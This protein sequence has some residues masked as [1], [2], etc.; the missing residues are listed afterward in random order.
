MTEMRLRSLLLASIFIIAMLTTSSFAIKTVTYTSELPRETVDWEGYHTLP[1]F[2]PALGNLVSVNFT[3]SLNATMDG[4]A[5]NNA[6]SWFYDAYFTADADMYVDMLNGEKLTLQLNLETDHEDLAPSTP[7]Y[8]GGP[9]YFA[10]SDAGDTSGFIYYNDA[11]KDDFVGTGNINL[12]TKSTATSKVENSG[13]SYFLI[14]TYSWT[15]ASITYTYDECRSCI[16][17]YKLDDCTKLGVKDWKVTLNNST[18]TTSTFTDSA[19]KYE[20][21]GLVPGD[22]IIT[23]DTPAGY[24]PAGPV[25]IAA[26]LKC[27]E[28]L[29]DQNFTNQ[30]LLCISG[31]KIN[32]STGAGLP[33][34]NITLTNASGSVTAKTGPDGKYQFC[35]LLPG[36]YSLTEEIVPGYLVVQKVSNPF[37][38]GCANITNKN[39]TNKWVPNLCG[40]CW[41]RKPTYLAMTYTGQTCTANCN[42]Q[43]A[44][45]VIVTGDPAGATPVRIVVRDSSSTGTIWFDRTVALGD[46]FV[47]DPA[48]GGATTLGTNT[49]VQISSSSG[50]VLQTVL[51]HTSCSQP[52]RP[53]DMYGSLRLEGCT[54]T[55]P[56]CPTATD[57]AYN[58][59]ND[60]TLAVAASQGVLAND[61]GAEITILSNTQPGNGT[62]TLNADGSFT[63][64]PKAGYCGTDRFSYKITG[65]GCD[66]GYQ[67]EANVTLNVKCLWCQVSGS[68][69]LT[70]SGKQVSWKITNNGAEPQ[71]IS[72]IYLAWPSVNKKEVKVMLNGVEI[73]SPDLAAPSATINSGWKGTVAARTI[74]AGKTATLTFEFESTACTDQSGYTINV[75]FS[76]GCSA[77]L[78]TVVDCQAAGGS[79]LTISAKK[80]SWTIKNNG[81]TPLDIGGIDLTWPQT[82]GKEMKVTLDGVEIYSPDLPAPSASF[83]SG[84]KGTLDARTI[85]PGQARILTFEFEKTASTSQSGYTINVRLNPACSLS[86]P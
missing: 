9:D 53:G 71:D 1:K 86:F 64:V 72:S 10:A 13:N 82:N 36:S 39:F 6:N 19:G 21:C 56:A 67:D 45:K 49:Y 7:P 31:Y 29:T 85:Q 43:A 73:Y 84:W 17:G 54:G 52:L 12:K 59:L 66:E 25:S 47:I 69:A 28:N 76:S 33:G 11:R 77:N 83:C 30:K 23:E 34:W 58:A 4:E 55:E 27:K 81:V 79:A 20:F 80:V 48:Y 68:E 37:T 51:F 32:S 75:Q 14:M 60:T 42:A 5:E 3:A 24:I 63:Y 50:T 61:N 2:D 65:G 74:G 15:N 38:L 18:Y 26:T 44:G 8:L 22:Y 40:E 57:D 35:N 70:F 78:A 46:T 16:S 62:V 41:E